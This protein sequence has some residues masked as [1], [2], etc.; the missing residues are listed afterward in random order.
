MLKSF[1]N[2]SGA[3]P[4]HQIEFCCFLTM[5][6]C[7]LMLLCVANPSA[8]LRWHIHLGKRQTWS[9]GFSF[10]TLDFDCPFVLDDLNNG[11]FFFLIGASIGKTCVSMQLFLK[12]F[13]IVIVYYQY[14][15]MFQTVWITFSGIKSLEL[16]W[17]RSE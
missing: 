16:N 15:E 10:S 8:C 3:Q 14:L 4:Y 12:N 2:V 5:Q 13:H 11:N 1:W 9:W 6:M 17:I 7:I